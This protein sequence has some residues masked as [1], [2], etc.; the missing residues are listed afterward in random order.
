VG[1]AEDI[2]NPKQWLTDRM[3]PG[4]AYKE[5]ADQPALSSHIDLDLAHANSRSFRRL[6]HAVEQLLEDAGP[7]P[8]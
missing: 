8:V 2:V 4:R 5:T 3:P 6:C 1:D 7:A